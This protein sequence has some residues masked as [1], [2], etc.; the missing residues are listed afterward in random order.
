MG[1]V[2]RAHHK[3]AGSIF[4]SHTHHRKGPVR[5]CSLDFGE[6]NG[7]LKGVVTEIIHDP[8]RGAPL[9]RVTFRH[10]FR[11][12][13][14]NELFVAAE[15]MHTGQFLY[16][17]KKANLMVGNVM[18]LRSIREGVVNAPFY[19]NRS[20]LNNARELAAKKEIT[21]LE[22]LSQTEGENFMSLWSSSKTFRADYERRILSS[23][24]MRQLSRDGRTRNSDE[25]LLV[26][27]V[28]APVQAPASAEPET[29]SRLS[30][31]RPKEESKPEPM[32]VLIKKVP[33]EETNKLLESETATKGGEFE[34]KENI[35]KPE[36][37]QE[38]SK[39]DVVD[40]TKWKEMK[41][42]EEIAKAKVALERKK[43]QAEKSA[44]KAA[45]R[46]QK[47][48]EKKLKESI[49]SISHLY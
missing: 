39:A 8:G 16:C 20:L 1:R 14:Q 5:F 18:P 19:Q 37:L 9:A 45:I 4:K 41:R 32:P 17:R 15:G 24:D 47:E 42:E 3:E 26:P 30:T 11:Y 13:H 7:Y 23:L 38:T 2:I 34:N 43:K 46:V 28:Q 44:A 25:K 10:H 27:P 33:K 21:A 49:L 48:A 35:S 12:K 36:K 40:A 31:K 29:I 6:R 22:E